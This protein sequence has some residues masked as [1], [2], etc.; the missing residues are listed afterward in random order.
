ME[1]NAWDSQPGWHQN[2]L[3]DSS[4]GIAGG[5]RDWV[6]GTLQYPGTTGYQDRGP[7][8]VPCG[9]Y[10]ELARNIYAGLLESDT[11]GGQSLSLPASWMFQGS[12]VKRP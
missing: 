11:L 2:T 8:A 4:L 10:L 12:N 6:T 9:P 7:Q 5:R 1:A 3:R